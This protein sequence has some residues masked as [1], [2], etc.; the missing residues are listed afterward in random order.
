MIELR[1]PFR[2][3]WYNKNPF[4]EADKLHGEVFRKLESRRT[5]RFTIE[6]KSYFIKIHYGTTLKEVLK[7]LVALRLPVLGADR[8]WHAIHR[9]SELGVD[10]NNAQ[11]TSA[12]L[13][14]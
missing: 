1:E 2:T 10:S 13:T 5:L 8:E 3:L 14:V 9:L 12:A 7:N 4:S 6:D 11:V